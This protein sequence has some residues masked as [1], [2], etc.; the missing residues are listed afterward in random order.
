MFQGY[1]MQI[2]S[3]Y[4]KNLLNVFN[5]SKQ[6]W[7]QFSILKELHWDSLERGWLLFLVVPILKV[8]R[9]KKT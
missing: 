4:E 7:Q 2:I 8:D 6:T 9:I 5:I 3:L 1:V